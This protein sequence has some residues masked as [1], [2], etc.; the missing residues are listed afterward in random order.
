[1]IFELSRLEGAFLI[2]LDLHHD[3]RGAF[4]RT[5][6]ER[7]MAEHGIKGSFV[8]QNMSLSTH[9]G[10][11]RG[12]HFQKHPHAEGKLIRCIRGAVHDVIVDIRR[13]SPTYLQSQSYV[14]DDRNKDQLYIPPGF[15]HGF[16][17]LVDDVEMTYLMNNFYRPDAEAGLRFDDPALAIDWPLPAGPIS[18][19]DA[20][21]PLLAGVPSSI[22][23]P[24]FP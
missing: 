3:E 5:M 1:M 6:C 10:T 13:G 18:Q 4:A 16:Q 22:F 24:P 23:E 8:Q 17:T 2:R 12:M 21:W 20:C 11:I 9:A 14:L 7:E 19:R 15:A